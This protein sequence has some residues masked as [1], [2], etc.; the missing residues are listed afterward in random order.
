MRPSSPG[1]ALAAL[2]WVLPACQDAGPATARPAPVASAVAAGNAAAAT[3]AIP[4]PPPVV[5][6]TGAVAL[7]AVG[8][9]STALVAGSE[10]AVDPRSRFRV[11]L[12]LPLPDARLSLLDGGDALVPSTGSRETG[13]TTVLALT[14]AAAL[15]AGARFRLRVDGAATRELQAAEGRRFAPLEWP[16]VVAGAPAPRKAAGKRGPRR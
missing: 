9:T 3:T 8:S 5:D 16:V 12:P 7:A 11:E 6:L 14:P 13:Q 1:L 10:T 15:A 2:A 4:A